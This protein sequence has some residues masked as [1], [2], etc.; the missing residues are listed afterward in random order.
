M[1]LI[2]FYP[3]SPR[4]IQLQVFSMKPM[5]KVKAETEECNRQTILHCELWISGYLLKM[6]L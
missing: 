3:I 4:E 2:H 1:K 5:V 6:V